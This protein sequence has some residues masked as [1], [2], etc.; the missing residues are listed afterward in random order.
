MSQDEL[1]RAADDK[2]ALAKRLVQTIEKFSQIDGAPKI[3]RKI[4]QEL[5][6]L[7]KVTF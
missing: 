7:E 6:F 2:I 3:Q 4:T 5:K 1:S